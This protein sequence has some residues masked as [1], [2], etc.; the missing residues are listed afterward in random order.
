MA[1]DEEDIIQD[2]CDQAEDTIRREREDYYGLP[3]EEGERERHA[4][5]KIDA[6]VEMGDTGA[7]SP[8]GK[9]H[10]NTPQDQ[11]TAHGTTNGS[12]PLPKDPELREDHAEDDTNH[13][14]V[15]GDQADVQSQ[16]TAP[17]IYEAAADDDNS[18]DL[19]DIGEEVVEAG[20]DTVIY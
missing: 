2:Q 3:I 10:E 18:K 19:D 13:E 4:S 7:N 17:A 5:R 12:D 20:E 9:E 6:D 14:A 8:I 15:N 16:L 1:S 11:P